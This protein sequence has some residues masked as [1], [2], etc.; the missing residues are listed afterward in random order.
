MSGVRLIEQVKGIAFAGLCIFNSSR[1][2]V[3]IS[4]N[5]FL[6]FFQHIS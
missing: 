1:D 5:Y 6:D 4:S 3:L 2:S